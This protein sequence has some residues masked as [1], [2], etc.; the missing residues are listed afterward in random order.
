MAPKAP[1]LMRVI[2]IL[3]QIHSPD[4]EN[5]YGYKEE[6][7]G[8]REKTRLLIHVTGSVSSLMQHI[9][10][11]SSEGSF[12]CHPKGVAAEKETNCSQYQGLLLSPEGVSSV[13]SGSIQ[14]IQDIHWGVHAPA[15]RPTG[16]KKQSSY[17][18]V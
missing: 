15:K 6:G 16:K 18:N 1:T 8:R 3:H 4:L 11:C 14:D 9:R 7:C 10:S 13:L 12:L 17:Q 5:I 2:C